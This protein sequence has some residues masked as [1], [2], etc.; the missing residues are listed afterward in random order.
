[1]EN[2]LHFDVTCQSQ[3]IAA[4]YEELARKMLNDKEFYEALKNFTD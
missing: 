2:K 3:E 4:K 1:M